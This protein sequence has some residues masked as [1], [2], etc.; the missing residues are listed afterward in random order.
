[1]ND[2]LNKERIYHGK[3][4]ELTEDDVSY[5]S[6]HFNG[7]DTE[8]LIEYCKALAMVA[9][10]RAWDYAKSYLSE[11][12]FDKFF[13]TCE[14]CDRSTTCDYEFSKNMCGD[15]YDAWIPITEKTK[16]EILQRQKELFG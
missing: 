12:G 7:I 8:D 15:R 14:N 4:Y 11:V 1:M 10:F 3:Y 6:E 13:R 9:S 5:I 2:E 16:E